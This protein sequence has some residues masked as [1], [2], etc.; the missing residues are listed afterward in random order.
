M[1]RLFPY[2]RKSLDR[3]LD[4]SSFREGFHE[5]RT[6]RSDILA[7]LMPNSND[8]EIAARG[9]RVHSQSE[10]LGAAEVELGHC[11]RHLAFGCHVEGMCPTD[12]WFLNSGTQIFEVFQR[13]C[14]KLLRR[15]DITQ[16][17]SAV[18]GVVKT[19]GK[20]VPIA[21]PLRVGSRF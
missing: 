9:F 18:S 14:V 3:A 1:A 7:T 12:S 8:V 15:C 17:S 5:L 10:K 6:G 2:V 11:L 20:C 4:H 16:S 13:A 21:A 19:N